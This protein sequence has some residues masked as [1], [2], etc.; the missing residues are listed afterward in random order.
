[1]NDDIIIDKIY[2]YYN[3]YEIKMS[4]TLTEN[5]QSINRIQ[6]KLKNN[7]FT[8]LFNTMEK[9]LESKPIEIRLVKPYVNE[10]CKMLCKLTNNHSILKDKICDDLYNIDI[11]DGDNCE[12]KKKQ[13]M[14]KCM[15]K[16]LFWV[17]I[18]QPQS[19]SDVTKNIRTKLNESS[20]SII[21]FF[22][23]FIRIFYYHVID[24][25]HTSQNTSM[26]QPEVVASKN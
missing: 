8:I 22:K 23:Y 24:V 16:M 18:L 5:I 26:S 9:D 6:Y 15:E 21:P 12:A 10:I 2:Y 20:G 3:L 25:L 1:M 13:I 19:Y 14:K 11:S 4:S 17:E 7:F